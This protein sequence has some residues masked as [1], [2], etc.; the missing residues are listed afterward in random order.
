MAP[1]P[2]RHVSSRVAGVNGP[3]RLRVEQAEWDIGMREAGFYSP[4]P[5]GAITGG[6]IG[7]SP[8]GAEARC[9]NS[10][11]WRA[12]SCRRRV[13]GHA[14][15]VGSCSSCWPLGPSSSLRCASTCLFLAFPR[16]RPRRRP[17]P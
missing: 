4:A 13:Q 2:R 7:E 10:G 16:P 17:R 14:D 9:S 6:A 12:T 11:T 3:W 1:R 8:L 5:R 15:N